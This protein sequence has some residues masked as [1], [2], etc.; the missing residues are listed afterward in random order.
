LSSPTAATPSTAPGALPDYLIIGAQKCGTSS[1]YAYLRQHPQIRPARRK[2]VH[3]FEG[4]FT[5]L[6]LDWYR[7]FFPPF[8]PDPNEPNA[9]SITGEASPFYLFNPRV[10][11]RVAQVLPDVKL[12]VILRNP[13]ERA[14]SH[15]HHELRGGREHLSFTGAI[16]AEDER[17]AGEA[18]KLM[19]DDEYRSPTFRTKS[20]KARGIYFDQLVRWRAYFPAEQ[21]LILTTQQLHDAHDETLD[22]TFEFLGVRPHIVEDSRARNS[23]PYPPMDPSIREELVDFFAPHNQRLYEFLGVDYGWS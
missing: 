23:H 15:Y 11:R 3:Y 19:A 9:V 17:L 6:S 16:E 2:E 7:S 12:I 5:R 8:I 14:Y 20:Y 22:Q 18:E 13:V 1:L 21:M 10:P 4:S